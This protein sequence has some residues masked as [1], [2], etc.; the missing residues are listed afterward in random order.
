MNDSKAQVDFRCAQ[1]GCGG[2]VEFQLAEITEDNFQS[3]CPEC[4]HA[5]AF[6]QELTVK[7]RKLRDLIIAVRA[8]EDILGDCNV[9]VT[10]PGGEVKVPYALLL[11]RLNTMISL[12]VGDQKVDFHFWVEPASPETFR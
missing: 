1:P 4:H 11:T 8:A 2:V 6:N 10:V 12:D 5:Y 7:F 3:V 9:A